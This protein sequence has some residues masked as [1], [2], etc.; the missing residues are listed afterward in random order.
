MTPTFVETAQEYARRGWRVL[1]LHR[2]GGELKMCSCNRGGRCDSAG[3]HPKDLE[4]QKKPRMSGPEIQTTW[5]VTTPPNIGLATGSESGFWVLDI[6]PGS[7]GFES[8][9]ALVSEHGKLPDT[10]VVRTGSGGFHYYFAMPPYELRN[11]QGRLGKGIDTRATGGQVV[12]PPSVSAKGSYDVVQDRPLAQAPEWMLEA[13]KRQETA[14]VTSEQLPK[15]EDISESEWDRLNAYATKAISAELTRLDQLKVT[16]WDGEPWNATTFQVS[17]SLLEF[18]NSPWCSYSTGQARE[19]VLQH[20]PRD[21]EGFDDW[22]VAKTFDSALAKVGPGARSVPVNRNPAP[23]VDPLF[24]GPDVR[25]NPTEGG[26]AQANP[27]APQGGRRNLFGGDEGKTPLYA[28]MA[29]AVYDDGPVGWGID[30]DFWGF[31][32][33]VWKPNHYIVE[34]RLIPKLGNAWRTTHATHTKDIVRYRAQKITGDPV[35]PVMNFRNGGLRWEASDDL[36]EHDSTLGSTVQLGCDWDTEATCPYFDAFLADVMHPDYVALAWEMIGYLMLSGNPLQMAFMFYG[37]GGNGKGTL[38]DVLGRLLG[39]ENI[40]AESLDNLATNR[41]RTANLFGKIANLAGDIDATY[42]ESTATFK[43]ITG[44]DMITAERKNG[45]PFRFYCW[46]V[47]V[48]SANKFPGSSDVT[49]GYLRRWTILHFHKRIPTDKM[50][51][52]SEL[53]ALFEAELS[54][55]A[56]KGVR[57]LRNLMDRG[58]FAPQGEAVKGKEEFAQAIDQVRQWVTA[59]QVSAAPGGGTP[60]DRL[61]QAYTYWADRTG[62]RKVNETEFSHRLDAIGYPRVETAGMIHHEGISVPDIPSQTPANFF[63]GRSDESED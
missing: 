62:K 31:E 17:C 37:S 19:D 2:V 3:K 45:Q 36:E 8:M 32:R 38:M 29:A 13:L 26:G 56:L 57:A 10:F 61:Y 44:E 60:I 58:H 25:R 42:Q 55:I 63:G 20:A 48:F 40:A 14:Q 47:P 27:A 53:M 41:F 5:D 50:K 30:L 4:W 28:E 33:G 16:G 49:D 35:E 46:A 39:R 54:G 11:T 6:D 59:G 9:A 51:D 52:R 23:E 34:D 18:A 43:G 24:G 15:P 21:N 22:T 12:A 1:P 7:G